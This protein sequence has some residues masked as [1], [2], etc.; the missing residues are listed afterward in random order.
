M[1]ALADP[2]RTIGNILQLGTIERIDLG[3]ATCRV[4]VGDNVTGDIPWA[5][6]G[7]GQM[8]RVWSPPSVGE[9]CMLLCP[10]GDDEGG[11]AVLGIFSDTHPAP[12]SEPLV[13][14]EFKDGSRFSYDPE[15]HALKIQLAGEG[16]ALLEAPGGLKITAD[17][18]VEGDIN[19]TGKLDASGKITSSADVIGGGKSLK[20]HKHTGVTAGGGVSG[21]PQ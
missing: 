12:S 13:L 4:R 18:E 6:G 5:T 17:V 19:L 21:P 15:A 14:L 20:D 11:I 3:A 7:A 2:R 9:Q 10:E 8:L 1:S 16:T